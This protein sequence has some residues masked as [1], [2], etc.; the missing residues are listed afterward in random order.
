MNINEF[1]D[2]LRTAMTEAQDL[3]YT[4]K[5]GITVDTINQECCPIGA[6]N[7]TK[8]TGGTVDFVDVESI[9]EAMGVDDDEAAAFVSGFDADGWHGREESEPWFDLGCRLRHELLG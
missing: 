4:I 5:N 9:A 2:A 8:G 1:E 7:V 6:V 3:G